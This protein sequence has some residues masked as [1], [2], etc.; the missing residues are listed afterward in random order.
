MRKGSHHTKEALYKMSK[1]HENQVAWNKGVPCMQVTKDKISVA[2]KGKTS[3]FKGKNHTQETK[4]KL[5]EARKNQE[6]PFKGKQHTQTTK[7]S[8][9]KS[10]EKPEYRS[11]LSIQAKERW[12]EPKFV[13]M[14]SEI[15]KEFWEN[16][17][18]RNNKTELMKKLWLDPEWAEKTAQKSLETNRT[19]RPNKPEKKLLE[20]LE[21]ILPGIMK[22]TGDGSFWIE[23]KNPDFVNINGKK[24]IIEVLGCFWHGCPEHF[25]DTKKQKKFDDRIQLF[26]SFGYSTLGIWECE[27]NDLDAVKQKVVG[28]VEV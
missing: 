28:F 13:K 5:R 17:E 23:G 20:L 6:P 9:K 16:P 26:K 19:V 2:K 10:R 22:Y 24:Q 15:M 25:P 8:M 12:E 7:D 1:I 21:R 11:N 27:L 3:S 18:Y 14:M 4:C